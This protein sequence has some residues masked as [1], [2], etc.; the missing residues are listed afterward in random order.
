MEYES[1]GIPYI[2]SWK[3]SSLPLPDTAQFV[4][5]EK[6]DPTNTAKRIFQFNALESGNMYSYL[7][8]IQKM[9]ETTSLIS[10]NL[11]NSFIM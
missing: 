9:K 3:T 4:Y 6:D 1:N 10:Q 2:Q 8:L 5:S 11:Q 7:R